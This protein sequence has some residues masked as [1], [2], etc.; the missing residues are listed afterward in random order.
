MEEIPITIPLSPVTDLTVISGDNNTCMSFKS[1][2]G[3]FGRAYQPDV[4]VCGTSKERTIYHEGVHFEKVDGY[5]DTQSVQQVSINIET[6]QFVNVLET[7]TRGSVTGI[8][9]SKQT[10]TVERVNSTQSTLVGF[11]QLNDNLAMHTKHTTYSD[12]E[13]ARHINTSMTHPEQK[14]SIN[15]NS[16]GNI[17]NMH[18][19]RKRKAKTVI[20]SSISNT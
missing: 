17:S 12:S 4:N 1:I 3:I 14:I 5:N 10:T 16:I 9:I 19:Y 20:Q 13:P 7:P 8:Y 2:A 18:M 6:T 15:R 11:A